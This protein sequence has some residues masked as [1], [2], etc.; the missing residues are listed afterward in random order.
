LQVPMLS[1]PLGDSIC[2]WWM[3]A[4]PDGRGRGAVASSVRRGLVA[5]RLMVVSFFAV[6]T[7]RRE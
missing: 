5:A 2:Q 4:L 3:H 6:T 7:P 1:R